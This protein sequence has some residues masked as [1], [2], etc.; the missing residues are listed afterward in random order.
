MR[1]VRISGESMAP[2]LAPGDYVLCGKSRLREGA[3][4]V[5]VHP[6]LG[7][8]VKRLGPDDALLSDGEGAE[9]DRLGSIADCEVLGR[10]WLAIRPSGVRRLRVRSPRPCSRPA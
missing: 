5:V 8:L 4:Y 9:P 1:L 6:R 2:T 7:R 3:V 10:A